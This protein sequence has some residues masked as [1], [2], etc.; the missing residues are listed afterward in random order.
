MEIKFFHIVQVTLSA[1]S[2]SARWLY[3]FPFRIEKTRAYVS[4]L[5]LSKFRT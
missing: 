4:L 1:A 5:D 3:Q 2:R